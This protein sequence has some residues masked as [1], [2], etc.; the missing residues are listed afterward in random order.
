MG[1]PLRKVRNAAELRRQVQ[2]LG[3]RDLI[4]VDT[5]GCSPWDREALG[6]MDTVLTGVERHLVIPATRDAESA[7]QLSHCFGHTRIRSLIITK[8]DEARGPGAALSATWGSGIPVSHL[9]HGPAIPDDCVAAA[10]GHL[11]AAVLAQAA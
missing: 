10:G 1:I 5:P 3:K 2:G 6:Y 8:M 11:H 7:R 9:C 4:L